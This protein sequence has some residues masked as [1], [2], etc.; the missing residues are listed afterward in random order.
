MPTNSKRIDVSLVGEIFARKEKADV[1]LFIPDRK[2]IPERPLVA[3]PS[4]PE[5]EVL[6]DIGTVNVKR[7]ILQ[8]LNHGLHERRVLLRRSLADYSNDARHIEITGKKSEDRD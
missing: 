4:A 6:I 1:F 2:A 5:T 7:F 8:A 3:N